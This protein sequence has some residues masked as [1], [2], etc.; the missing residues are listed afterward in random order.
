MKSGVYL[1]LIPTNANSCRLHINVER[2]GNPELK[3]AMKCV[4]EYIMGGSRL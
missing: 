4:H 2:I 1:K 3:A